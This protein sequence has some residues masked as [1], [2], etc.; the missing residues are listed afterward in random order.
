MPR[1]NNKDYTVEELERLI[2]IVNDLVM[3]TIL[4][5]KVPEAHKEIKELI[6][7]SQ[8]TNF[9]GEKPLVAIPWNFKFEM[10]INPE[11]QEMADTI[12]RGMR[13]SEVN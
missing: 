13:S 3:G 11:T 10:L 1:L 6:A 9:E 12:L 8:F 4:N 7:G 2:Y 5:N